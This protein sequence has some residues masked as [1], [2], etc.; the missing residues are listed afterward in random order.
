MSARPLPEAARALGVST[1]TLKR[2]L[3]QGAPVARRGR[4]GRGCRTLIDPEAIRAWRR[5][6]D[7]DHAQVEAVLRALAGRVP[8]LLAEAAAE[9]FRL[10]PDKRGAA[11][12]ACAVWQLSVAAV[13]DHLRECGADVGDPDAIPECI[14]RLRKIASPRSIWPETRNITQCP[15]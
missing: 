10:A 12:T 11:W 9:A 6:Q 1:P 8:E 13:L 2:W 3:R 5:A 14:E 4:R 7:A 15:P